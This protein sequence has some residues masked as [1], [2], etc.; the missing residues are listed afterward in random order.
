MVSF[1]NNMCNGTTTGLMGVCYT[2]RECQERG[3]TES[4]SC[5]AGF[6]VCCICGYFISSRLVPNVNSLISHFSASV[7]NPTGEPEKVFYLQNKDY[8]REND[9]PSISILNLP[10]KDDSICQLRLVINY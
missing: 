10:I 2:M 5:A 1:E 6:G 8:P 3:G 4:G 9:E 7:T